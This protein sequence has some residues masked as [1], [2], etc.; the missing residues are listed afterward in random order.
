MTR[1][2]TGRLHRASWLWRRLGTSIRCRTL[3]AGRESDWRGQGHHGS[4]EIQ[5]AP[6]KQVSLPRLEL[7]AAT[8]LSALVSHTQAII[9]LPI[10]NVHLWSD[11]TVTL[12]WIQGHPSRWKTYVANRVAEIQRCTPEARWHHT[13]GEDNPADCASRGVSPKELV[14]HELWWKGPPWLTTTSGPWPAG[15]ALAVTA[16]IP[17]QR[18]S[19][20]ASRP[21][22]EEPTLLTRYS[23][24]HRLLRIS[25]WC[26]RWLRP[27]HARGCT[28]TV[29]ELQDAEEMWIRISQACGYPEELATLSSN[30]ELPRRSSLLKLS[31]FIDGKGILRVGGRLRNASLSY[32]EKHPAILPSESYLTRLII[33]AS[34]RR[35][36]HGGVQSTLGLLRQRHWIPRGRTRVKEV[37]H[38]CVTCL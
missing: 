37:I 38:R 15:P 9:E 3:R 31:P 18:T 24:L 28:L 10:A 19:Y 8:L 4:S 29:E 17:E 36:L 35:T 27:R 6:V 34:H 13:P 11:S 25:A 14:D 1:P 32:D 12:S 20:A 2:P 22:P 7:C 16:E 26:R 21:H 23:S 33:E 5:V 30:R